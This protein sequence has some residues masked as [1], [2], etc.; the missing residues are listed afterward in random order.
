MRSVY[1]AA[2]HGRMTTITATGPAPAA[3]GTTRP[4]T[5]A[6]LD[7]LTG[8]VR[9]WR[10]AGILDESTASAILAGYH[11]SRRLDL[12]RLLLTL[13][14]AFVGV[15]LIWLVASNLDQLSPTLRFVVVAGCWLAFLV[16]GELLASRRRHGGT[17]ASPVVGAAR[18]LAALAFGAV[19]FQAAQ[20][21]QVPA[22]EPSL[23]AWWGLGALVHAY[24][25]RAAGPLVIGLLTL[26]GWLVW[27]T[28]GHQPDALQ[29]LL[30]VFAAGAL[31]ASAAALHTRWLPDFA[32]AWREVG[33]LLTLGAL[34]V[35]ALPY[36]RPDRIV[37]PGAL[38]G[39]VAVT[40]VLVT[41]GAVLTRGTHGLEPA[42]AAAI[43]GAGVLLVVWDA[44][45]HP[46]VSGPIGAA[47]WAH[48]GLGITAYVGAAGWYAV[49]GVLRDSRRLTALATAAL[50]L[51]TTVQAFAVFARIIEG[52]WLF[53][54]LGGVFV[55]TGWFADRARR[56]LAGSLAGSLATDTDGSPR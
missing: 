4:A 25:V 45:V 52:A 37:V 53:V 6:Q 7:W 13:G 3:P 11:P 27:Q 55:G 56:R 31:A 8:E 19:V 48:A 2:D 30:T 42:L 10:A 51:F 36:V 38:V 50:V 29:V 44:G 26:S 1:P 35:A 39:L 46:D 43:G 47:G 12:S 18:I 40:A 33:A 20:S 9:R 32:P 49:L 28:A 23:L 21:L 24:A 16:S 14:A 22:Y 41:A 15:G 54:V 17:I 5:P 34:F